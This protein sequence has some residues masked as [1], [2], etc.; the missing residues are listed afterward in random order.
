V[1]WR[2]PGA[3]RP[4]PVP[5]QSG[6]W[7]PTSPLV[8]R[9]RSHLG[10]GVDGVQRDRDESAVP[11]VRDGHEEPPERGKAMD[12]RNRGTHGQRAHRAV[13]VAREG[14]RAHEEPAGVVGAGPAVRSGGP[15]AA[16]R[17]GRPAGRRNARHGVVTVRTPVMPGAAPTGVPAPPGPAPTDEPAPGRRDPT[18]AV[19]RRAVGAD[20]MARRGREKAPARDRAD[21]AGRRVAPGPPDPPDPP[22]TKGLPVPRS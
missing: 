14:R 4:A 21:R 22:G 3:Q 17:V 9:A 10:R 16:R 13:P 18:P 7:P 2:A 1:P 20:R 15:P 5:I 11:A 6:A 8:P 19:A 12:P